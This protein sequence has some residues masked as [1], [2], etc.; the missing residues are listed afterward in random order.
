MWQFQTLSND[1]N[2][3][4]VLNSLM[5][6]YTYGDYTFSTNEHNNPACIDWYCNNWS[7]IIWMGCVLPYH[8]WSLCKHDNW[9][10]NYPDNWWCNYLEKYNGICTVNTSDVT[11]ISKTIVGCNL[12]ADTVITVK[13]T[14]GNS[15]A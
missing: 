5:W 13:Y 1:M 6:Y 11:A 15:Y 8:L 14:L 9:W 7:N 12:S 2:P 3:N 10:C 4:Q